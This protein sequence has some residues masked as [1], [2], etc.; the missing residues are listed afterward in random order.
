MRPVRLDRP[1]NS[2]IAGQSYSQTVQ[3]QANTGQ[4]PASGTSSGQTGLSFRVNGRG[5][6][7]GA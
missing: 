1:D 2:R 4:P 6:L 3:Q 7:G 5:W